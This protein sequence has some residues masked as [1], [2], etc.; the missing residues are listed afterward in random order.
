MGVLRYSSPLGWRSITIIS[1]LLVTLPNITGI[2]FQPNEGITAP[3]EHR[4]RQ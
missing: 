4:L 3:E 2:Q 1:S